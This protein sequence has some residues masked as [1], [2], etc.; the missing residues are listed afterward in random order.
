MIVAYACDLHVLVCLNFGDEIL[1]RGA[2]CKTQINLNFFEK[3]QN[4]KLP[5]YYR[6]Q[7]LNFLDP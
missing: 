6:L 5:L 1:L 2:K 3:G 4:V 7:T